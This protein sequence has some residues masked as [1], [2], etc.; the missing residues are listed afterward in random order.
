MPDG[1]RLTIRSL[2]NVKSR[3]SYG[4]FIWNDAGVPD[5]KVLVRVDLAR[6]LISVFRGGHEIGTAVILYGSDGTPTPTGL[7]PVL[8][9]HADYHS[10]TYDAPMPHMLRLTWDGV[11]LHASNVRRGSA[12]HGCIG[13]PPAFAERMF[14]ALSVGDPVLVEAKGS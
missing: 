11:A 8:E 1:T 4:Q 7:F 3:M 2:L 5:G 10:R 12:T 6:Q 9:K 13:T 14:A